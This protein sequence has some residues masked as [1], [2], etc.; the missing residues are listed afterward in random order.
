MTH[1]NLVGH[2]LSWTHFDSLEYL[3][4][5]STDVWNQICILGL[6]IQKYENTR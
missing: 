1:L 2:W 5:V 4:P 6:N 3:N